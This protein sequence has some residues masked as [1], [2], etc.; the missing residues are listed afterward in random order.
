MANGANIRC[1]QNNSQYYSELLSGGAIKSYNGDYAN[2]EA[3]QDSGGIVIGNGSGGTNNIQIKING[4]FDNAVN[5]VK[6]SE[7]AINIYDYNQETSENVRLEI[8]HEGMTGFDSNGNYRFGFGSGGVRF[9]DE[10][11]QTTAGLPLT[12]G[13]LNAGASINIP[14]I[15]DNNA[16][17]NISLNHDTLKIDSFTSFDSAKIDGGGLY[18]ENTDLNEKITVKRDAYLGEFGMRYGSTKIIFTD[19]SE[20]TTAYAPT[21]QNASI[22]YTLYDKEIVVTIDGVTYAMLARIV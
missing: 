16:E 19:N 14:Y 13:T 2:A 15:N 11:I 9:S 7:S 22:P 21:T 17:F 8:Y 18:V 6:I 10:T 12:G 3:S 1:Q 5:G 20:Q 4:W